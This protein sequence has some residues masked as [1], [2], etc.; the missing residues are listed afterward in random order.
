[1]VVAPVHME[2][3][4]NV[5]GRAVRLARAWDAKGRETPVEPKEAVV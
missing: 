4:S 3:T 1:M 5:S 2:A